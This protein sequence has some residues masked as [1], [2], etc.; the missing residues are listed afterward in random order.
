MLKLKYKN[1][2]GFVVMISV[3]IVSVIVLSISVTIAFLNTG[4]GKNSLT[5]KNSDQA[6]LLAETCSE[7][8]LLEISLDRNYLGNSN[9]NFLEGDC[10]YNVVSGAG[11]NRTIES[12]GFSGNSVRKEKILINAL[13]P[14]IIISSWQEIA[15]F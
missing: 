15:D 9:L 1:K 11:E 7:Q 4:A 6:R 10:S 2:P 3:L 13:N 5:L 12:S 8:A 14:D